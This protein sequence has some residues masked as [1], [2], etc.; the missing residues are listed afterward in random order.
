MDADK[1]VNTTRRNPPQS[2]IKNPPKVVSTL[3]KENKN[4]NSI[5]ITM[6]LT[7]RSLNT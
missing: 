1:Y 3:K 5:A 2:K 7:F 6:N 4:N